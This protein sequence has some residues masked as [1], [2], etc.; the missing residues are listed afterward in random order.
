MCHVRTYDDFEETESW[1]I[2]LSVEKRERLDTPEW[3]FGE[4]GITASCSTASWSSQW[5][6]ESKSRTSSTWSS[7][8]SSTGS[9]A[10]MSDDALEEPRLASKRESGRTRQRR[11]KSNAKEDADAPECMPGSRQRLDTPEFWLGDEDR[12]MCSTA[13]CSI[14]SVTSDASSSLFASLARGSFESTGS[15][16]ADS[17]IGLAVDADEVKPQPRKRESGR[18]RQRRAKANGRA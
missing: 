18:A 2:P 10:D 14:Q 13:R 8:T 15:D 1:N 9:W 6:F 5:A 4:S 7:G 12:S 3:F 16:V 17:L 11:A